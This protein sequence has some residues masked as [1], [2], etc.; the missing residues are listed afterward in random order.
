MEDEDNYVSNVE[1][2]MTN[3]YMSVDVDA[4]YVER[5]KNVEDSKARGYVG[6]FTTCLHLPHKQRQVWHWQPQ[7]KGVLASLAMGT[8]KP[9]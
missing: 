6:K 7:S 4:E 9:I 1:V 5:G 8:H 3:F 2:D